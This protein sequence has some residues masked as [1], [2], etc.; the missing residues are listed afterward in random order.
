MKKVSFRSFAFKDCIHNLYREKRIIMSAMAVEPLR[1]DE[2][3]YWFRKGNEF[4]RSSRFRE[5]AESFDKAIQI[6][7][8]NADAWNHRGLALASLNRFEEAARSFD[9]ACKAD[10]SHP[11]AWYNNGLVLC[12]LE[13]YEAAV[14][15]FEKALEINPQ[16]AHA[17]H[18][19][20]VALSRLG[21]D[22]QAR[23]AFSCAG[24]IGLHGGV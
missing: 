11:D 13:R 18:N 7:P 3:S 10:P 9:R 8:K 12:A 15:S 24:W 20:G 2:I 16:N 19:K 1:E 17:W 5:A 4:L 23:F 22:A 6:D 14:M 21:L